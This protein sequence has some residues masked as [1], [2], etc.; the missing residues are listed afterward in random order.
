[1]RCAQIPVTDHERAL[2]P[3]LLASLGSV[4]PDECVAAAQAVF[5]TYTGR[6]APLVGT[7]VATLLQNCRAVRTIVQT[8]LVSLRWNRSQLQP[9]V[10]AVLA[11][12]EV[13]PLTASLRMDLGVQA[14]PWND[15]TSLLERAAAANEL[16]ADALG[17]AVR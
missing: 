1:R 15:A 12:L 7:T 4:L 8:L 9:A 16:H 11:A 2:L 10:A 13:D 3:P 6:D 14:L 5:A 17:V